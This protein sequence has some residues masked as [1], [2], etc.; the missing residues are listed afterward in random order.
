MGEGGAGDSNYCRVDA[1]ETGSA[2]FSWQE[3]NTPA[4]WG[5]NMKGGSV[6]VSNLICEGENVW[7]QE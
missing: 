3:G 7:S 5:K 4:E 1:G 6:I 2:S